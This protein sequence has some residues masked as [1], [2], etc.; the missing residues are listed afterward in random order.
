[1]RLRKRLRN[2]GFGLL[3]AAT[4]AAGLRAGRARADQPH[5][6]AALEQLRAA[7]AELEFAAGDKG[8]HRARA[9]RLVV[10]A[11]GQVEMGIQY[12]RAH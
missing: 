4:V 10:D 1:M 12:D 7:R 6:R 9:V 11:I 2:F 3:L 5:M 8:G